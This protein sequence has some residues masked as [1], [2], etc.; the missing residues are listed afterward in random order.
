MTVQ[1]LRIGNRQF[2]LLAKRQFEK[3][4]A[5][6]QRQTE[7]EYWTKSALQA[8]AKSRLKNDQPIPFD[9]IESELDSRK[10]ARRTG[11][12]GRR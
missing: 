8:E 10:S 5:Q 1:T 3:L 6:A 4:A 12:R 11:R 2:V 9:Q 7:D